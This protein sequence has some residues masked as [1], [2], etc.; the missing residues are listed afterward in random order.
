MNKNLP[1]TGKEDYRLSK[2]M[3]VWILLASLLVNFFLLGLL[4][5]PVFLHLHM[6]PPFMPPP[7]GIIEHLTRGL[8]PS[9]AA[10]VQNVFQKN[11][12]AFDE[13]RKNMDS[14]MQ[15]MLAVL[16][17]PQLDPNELQK[18]LQNISTARS[19]LDEAMAN[20]IT[21][22]ATRLSPDG[23]RNIATNALPPPGMH[24]HLHSWSQDGQIV[25]PAFENS[26]QPPPD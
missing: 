2:S 18:A 26:A 25:A 22:T 9:D 23:R 24:M 11:E 3:G 8:S 1:L 20:S 6:P 14:A 19:K 12:S 15:N 10:I 13:S 16:Q 5:A 4:V 7:N 17:Q 21:Q